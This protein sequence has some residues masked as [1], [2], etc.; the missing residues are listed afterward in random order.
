MGSKRL[1]SPDEEKELA[2]R[3]LAAETQAR[4]AVA[5]TE[6]AEPYL[7]KK[8]KGSERTRAGDVDR[9]GQAID[10][11]CHAARTDPSLRSIAHQAKTAWVEAEQLRWQ[12]AMTAM[13]VAR[14]EARKLKGAYLDDAD[15]VQEGFVGLMRAAKRFDPD[16]D[17]RFTTYARW[18]VRAQMTRAIDHTGRLVRLPG[19]AVEQTRNLRK[20]RRNLDMIGDDY[21]IKDLA[22]EAGIEAERAEFLLSRGRTVS[23]HEP[24]DAGPKSRPVEHFL[25]DDDA[26]DPLDNAVLRQEVHR[27]TDAIDAVLDDHHRHVIALRYGLRDNVFRSLSEI[28]RGM[29]LSRERVRQIEREALAC[30]RQQGQIREFV[31]A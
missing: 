21:T 23:I 19:C 4:A 13:H 15:L 29:A 25:S 3:I 7:R 14:G 10:A 8:R 27:L 6:P 16:R 18:W 20:A 12:L 9:L 31:A 24:V 2:R 30:L 26:E 22:A 11:V 5:G 1:R 17:I 28:A